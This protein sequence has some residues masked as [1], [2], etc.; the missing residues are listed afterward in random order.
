MTY[1][2]NV[3]K[4]FMSR[5]GQFE[6]DK[7]TLCLG[8]EVQAL[9]TRGEYDPTI[10]KNQDTKY[11]ITFNEAVDVVVKYGKEN[12]IWKSKKGSTFILPITAFRIVSKPIFEPTEKP[13]EQAQKDL[14]S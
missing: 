10:G 13:K 14:F 5:K 2:Y 4:P 1:E 12:A 7:H 8:I 11:F 6:P 9:R 3:N